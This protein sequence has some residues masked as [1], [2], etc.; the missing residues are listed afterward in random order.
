MVDASERYDKLVAEEHER[1][2]RL[3]KQVE[4]EMPTYGRRAEDLTLEQQQRDYL[5]VV[6]TPGGPEGVQK[7][8]EA[9]YGLKRS[10]FALA[11]WG[12]EQEPRV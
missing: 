1:R 5:E 4:A 11:D 6:N 9:K 8:W 10:V 7:E 12:I 2:R 3:T